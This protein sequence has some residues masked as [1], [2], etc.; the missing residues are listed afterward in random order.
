MHMPALASPR[1]KPQGPS[2]PPGTTPPHTAPPHL[3]LLQHQGAH[4]G[5]FVARRI[6]LR[7]GQL[8]ADGGAALGDDAAADVGGEDDESVLE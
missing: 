5:V 8:K 1:D 2:Q 3:E 7:A 6:P 4:A